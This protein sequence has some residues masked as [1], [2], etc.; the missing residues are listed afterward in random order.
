MNTHPHMYISLI[1]SQKKDPEHGLSSHVS[2]QC[3]G[4]I[5][6]LSGLRTKGRYVPH[7]CCLLPAH[8]YAQNPC[9]FFHYA[10]IT[11]EWTNYSPYC[12]YKSL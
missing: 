3:T 1:A 4:G 6:I 8:R 11:Y 12:L 9:Q 5:Y 10:Y 7:N 2:L